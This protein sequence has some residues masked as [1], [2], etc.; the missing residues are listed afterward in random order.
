[1]RTRALLFASL[2]AA[3]VGTLTTRSYFNPA[4]GEI[5]ESGNV[6][7]RVHVSAIYV[8]SKDFER[9]PLDCQEDVEQTRDGYL[10]LC[11]VKDGK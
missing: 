4:F 2:L 3:C 1:M 5:T 8:G 6:R 11:T 7:I 10:L 9:A